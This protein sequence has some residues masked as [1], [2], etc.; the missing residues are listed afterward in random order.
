M[1]GSRAG[2]TVREGLRRLYEHSGLPPDGG[3]SARSWTMLRIGSFPVR[4]PGFEWRRKAVA[5]HDIHHLVTGYACNWA[6]EIEIANWEFAAGRY[7][8]AC[9]TLFCL[10]LVAAGALSIPRRSFAAFVR[11]RHS[12]TLYSAAGAET[13][14]NHQIGALQAQLLPAGGSPRARLRDVFL[15]AG[16]VAVALLALLLPVFLVA[17]LLEKSDD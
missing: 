3:A 5:T 10:P 13:L 4:M 8:H 2:V 7:P 1:N 14:M 6:G 9:A 17:M 15:Y 16:L 11:G 12:R